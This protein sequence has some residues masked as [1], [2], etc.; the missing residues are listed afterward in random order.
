LTEDGLR[1]IKQEL[2]TRHDI[3]ATGGYGV[4]PLRLDAEAREVVEE[5]QDAPLQKS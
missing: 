5:Y 4:E 1:F 3:I 2:I